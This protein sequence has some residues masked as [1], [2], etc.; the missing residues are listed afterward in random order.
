M[1]KIPPGETIKEIAEARDID[2]DILVSGLSVDVDKLL[3]G[4]I[5]ITEQVAEELYSIF[6][7]PTSFWLNLQ[8]IYDTNPKYTCEE[9]GTEMVRAYKPWCPMCEK[10]EKHTIEY[11]DMNNVLDYLEARRPG[12]KDRLWKYAIKYANPGQNSYEYVQL[13][14]EPS[15]KEYYSEELLEDLKL[16]RDE[17][18]ID[19]GCIFQF[20]Y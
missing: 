5:A 6:S 13:K 17:F 15:E 20:D 4:D 14:L 16:L 3:A 9:C 1:L 11:Y 19:K 12:S 10:P 8:R 18:N 2:R 7:L